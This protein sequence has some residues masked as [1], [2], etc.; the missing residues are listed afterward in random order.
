MHVF[1]TGASSGIGEALAKEYA[2]REA[3]LSLVARR[4]DRLL[5]LQAGLKT[6]SQVLPAD[7][8]DPTVV[9][10]LV[11]QA[12]AALGPIDILI[13]NAG[14]QLVGSAFAVS[15]EAAE[16]SMR[17]NYTVPMRLIRRV[18][19]AMIARGQGAVVNVSSM[20][21]VT[22]TPW[23]ADYSG[24]KAALGASSEVLREELRAS[25]VSVLT[26]YPGPVESP[27]EAAARA[28]LPGAAARLAPTGTPEELARKIADAVADQDARLIYPAVYNLGYL[29]RYTSQWVTKTFTPRPVS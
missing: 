2:R 26:V 24:S 11:A 1:L 28:K 16:A 23:M 18:V 13:N 27:M 6:K 21:G 10:G 25:G 7:L 20:A 9:E 12:I 22:W 14:S 5:E 17:L 3:R 29:F 19:P 8:S 4:Q 15:D